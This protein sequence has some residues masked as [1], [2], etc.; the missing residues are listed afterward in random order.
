MIIA[1]ELGWTRQS[2]GPKG[3]GVKVSTMSAGDEERYVAWNTEKV[4]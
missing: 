4:S 3:M 2:Q 1:E